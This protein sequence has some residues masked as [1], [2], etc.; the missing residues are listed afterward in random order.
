[1]IQDNSNLLERKYMEEIDESSLPFH[2]II[3]YNM[4]WCIHSYLQFWADQ[5]TELT[6]ECVLVVE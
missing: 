6:Y 4:Y 5:P 2:R 3:P 1:M